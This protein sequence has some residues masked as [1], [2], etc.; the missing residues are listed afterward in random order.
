[1]ALFAHSKPC[2][3]S[4]NIGAATLRSHMPPYCVS[5][6]NCNV[7]NSPST[8]ILLIKNGPHFSHQIAS[9]A[10]NKYK[11]VPVQPERLLQPLSNKPSS[12]FLKQKEPY[13]YHLNHPSLFSCKS[14]CPAHVERSFHA[15]HFMQP[16]QCQQFP[17]HTVSK[18]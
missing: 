5:S 3:L 6:S 8:K 17:A 1:M 12:F 4:P 10:S 11:T 2:S 18:P 9:R 15:I 7:N 14:I 16:L 13:T